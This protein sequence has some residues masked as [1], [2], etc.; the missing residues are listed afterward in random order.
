MTTG[1]LAHDASGDGARAEG[2]AA[3]RG[4]AGEPAPG[5]RRPWWVWWVPFALLFAVLVVRNRYLF[6]AHL[7]EQGDSGADSI[8]MEQARRLTLLVGN[9]SREGFNHPGPAY[10]YAQAAGQTLFTLIRLVPT[11]W[12]GQLLTVY[13]MNSG[14]FALAAGVVYGWTRS[15]RAVL[16]SVA[17]AAAFGV[18]YPAILSSNWMPDMYVVPY[19]TFVVAAASV[20]AG[21]S[22]DAW[23]MA[24][25]GWFLIHGHACFLFFVPVITCAVLAVAAWP[26]RRAPVAALRSFLATR[27]RV[28]VPVAVISA[29]FALPIVINLALHWPGD[30]GKYFS[31]GS[32][33][34]AG[35]HGVAQVVQYAAQF[36]WPHEYAG[37]V[38]VLAYAVAG[39]LVWKLASGLPRRFLVALLAL[40]VVS[41]LAFGFYAAVGVDNL[42]EQYIG[43]FYWSAPAITVLVMVVAVVEALP[44]RPGVAVAAAAAAMAVVALAVNPGTHTDLRDNDP[45]LPS[46]VA[47]IAAGAHGR[48]IV[49]TIDPYTWIQVVGFLVQGERTGVHACV[50]GSYWTYLMSSQF[51]C[52][53]GQAAAGAPFWFHSGA[54]TP[55]SHVVEQ[56]DG[57]TVTSG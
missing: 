50:V 26:H 55:G 4:A 37:A 36:W 33:S 31:Y 6:T 40:N 9:Y 5:A 29:V 43:Y 12:N 10:M 53:P 52:T 8:L 16:A 34:Q 44:A 32:S 7:Y 35:G 46:A 2:T 23:V 41:T 22:Q 51:V 39:I 1:R 42:S 13:A 18:A 19:F 56:F 30:F 15:L 20:A 27:R 45:A 3:G 38:P 11:A 48:T 47:A 21:R 25:T 14:F 54:A 49:L 17:V 57:V 28:W 24:L